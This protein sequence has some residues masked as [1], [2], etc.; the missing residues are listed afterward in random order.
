[1]RCIWPASSIL[2]LRTRM[3]ET[4]AAI[5]RVLGSVMDAKMDVKVALGFNPNKKLKNSVPNKKALPSESFFRMHINTSKKIIIILIMAG[6]CSNRVIFAELP[7]APFAV[8]KL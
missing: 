7:Y 3:R 4:T 5:D 2:L 1:M 8:A 6:M